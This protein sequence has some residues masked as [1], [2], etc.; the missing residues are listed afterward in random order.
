[1]P[2]R[3]LFNLAALLLALATSILVARL[4]TTEWQAYRRAVNGSQAVGDLRLALLAAEMVSRERGPTNGLL[5]DVNVLSPE[6]VRALAEARG[7]SDSAL[8]ALARMMAPRGDGSRTAALQTNAT[9][10]AGAQAALA[11][12]RRQIDTL[13]GLARADRPPEEL[14]ARVRA[15]AAVVQQLAPMIGLLADEAQQALPV[16][17]DDVQ[18]ARLAA[19]LREYAGL[20]GSH[21]TAALTRQQPFTIDE[22][23]AI[24]RT[25]GRID[26]LRFLIELRVLLPGQSEAVLQ[27]WQQA[28]ARYFDH[29]GQLLARVVA[30]G[31]GDGQ[32]GLDPAGFAAAYVPPM[33]SLLALRDVLLAQAEARARA[34]QASAVRALLLM[35]GGAALLV[36]LLA[37]TVT[38]LNRRI[39]QP[40]AA[41]TEALNALAR[42]APPPPLPKPAADDEIAAVVGAVQTLQQAL[43]ARAALAEE[44]D[45][46]IAQLRDQSNTD[47][48]TGLPNRRA[49]FEQAEREIA[50]AIR[51]GYGIAVILLDVDHFKQLNDSHGHASGDQALIEVAGVVRRSLRQGDLVARYGGEEIVVLLGHSDLGSGLRFAE[52]L[53]EAIAS[54]GVVGPLGQVI[55]FTASLGVADSQQHGLTLPQL[56]SRADAAMYAAKQ[57]GRNRVCAATLDGAGAT[58]AG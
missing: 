33:N 38:L 14:R 49:F 30:I 35:G 10:V 31:N 53:R 12:A 34:E 40:L 21:F 13:A 3:R 20:L 36:G 5:G 43:Q 9:P 26:E 29:A 11:D 57:A 18:G 41:T 54:S 42:N 19:E 52:R 28:G 6:R 45:L 55:R 46:L 4:A 51:H 37:A 27:A 7:R 2:L 8:D 39:L 16:L 15:M 22:R 25:R 48:L 56:L 50:Q 17:N 24:E 32:Y 58:S 47:F 1:M 44:R 23:A